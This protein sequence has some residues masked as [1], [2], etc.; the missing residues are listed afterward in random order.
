MKIQIKNL[1]VRYGSRTIFDDFSFAI[2][3][4]AIKLVGSNG[5]GKSTL[6]NHIYEMY[7]QECFL[8]YQEPKYFKDFSVIENLK[9]MT[10]DSYDLDEFNRVLNY[11]E[12][13]YIPKK[14]ISKLSGGELQICIL[15]IAYASDKKIVLLDEI[16]NNLDDKRSLKLK[17]FL[18]NS[19]KDFIIVSHNDNI[20]CKE[21]DLDEMV[22]I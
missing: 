8:L 13:G 2:D 21:V 17:D 22:T 12:M 1:S 14:T 9:I 6:L 16:E 19:Y 7:K 10:M 4:H 3:G 20:S 15:A 11:F 5:I 18:M